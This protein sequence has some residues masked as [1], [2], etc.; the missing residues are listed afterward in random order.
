MS[1]GHIPAFPSRFNPGRTLGKE[2]LSAGVA[3]AVERL[4]PCIGEA[5]DDIAALPSLHGCM[6]KFL[7]PEY[8]RSGDVPA[9]TE[10]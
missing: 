7:D 4:N 10:S 9:D 3:Q 5:A 1:T 2:G 8:G 6:E